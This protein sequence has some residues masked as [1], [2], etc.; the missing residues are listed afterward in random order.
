M[1]RKEFGEQRSYFRFQWKAVTAEK[2]PVYCVIC[3]NV[4]DFA[5]ESFSTNARVYGT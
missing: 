4:A 2:Q 1:G 3:S 5:L